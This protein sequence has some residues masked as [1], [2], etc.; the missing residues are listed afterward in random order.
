M[1]CVRMGLVEDRGGVEEASQKHACNCVCVCVHN[2]CTKPHLEECWA[3]RLVQGGPKGLKTEAS[4][5]QQKRSGM[6]EDREDQ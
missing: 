5:K 6:Q 3:A 4:S 2:I 1:G